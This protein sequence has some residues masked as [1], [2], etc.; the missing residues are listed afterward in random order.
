MISDL[1]QE[2][3]YVIGKLKETHTLY[4][5]ADHKNIHT[6]FKGK[7]PLFKL[8][9][10]TFSEDAPKS[11][12]VSFH[13]ELPVIAAIQW[14]VR[15]NSIHPL[16]KVC[17]V[18]FEDGAGEI[19]YGEDA[20]KLVEIKRDQNALKNYLEEYDMDELEKFTQSKIFG[21]NRESHKTFDAEA[22][23]NKALQEFKQMKKPSSD[24]EV[25]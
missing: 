8:L 6:F 10:G 24:D 19:Y 22:E 12:V 14:Y 1:Y 17:N 20:E 25:Q 13:I 21:R 11:I 23:H 7:I 15:I 5:E 4:V 9:F 3:L 2:Y 16:L 18:Y